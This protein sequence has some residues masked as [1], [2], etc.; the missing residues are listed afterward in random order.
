M[1]H[2]N[3]SEKRT[4]RMSLVLTPAIKDGITKVAAIKQI[5]VSELANI[6]FQELINEYETK[7]K[8]YDNFIAKLNDKTPTKSFFSGTVKRE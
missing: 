2:T 8:E 7:I 3:K 5:S 4:E 6:T 1:A